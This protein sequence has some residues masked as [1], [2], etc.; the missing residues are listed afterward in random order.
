M[1]E[2]SESDRLSNTRN[3]IL[4]SLL[5]VLASGIEKYW[6]ESLDDHGGR[7]NCFAGNADL[8]CG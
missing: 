3:A 6:S 7:Y 1:I 8:S 2:T 5:Y 4:Y